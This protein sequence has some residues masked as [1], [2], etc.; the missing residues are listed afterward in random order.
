MLA[1]VKEVLDA[2]RGCLRGGGRNGKRHIPRCCCPI[3]CYRNVT[4][5]W[6]YVCRKGDVLNTELWRIIASVVE[7]TRHFRIRHK[8]QSKK[9]PEPTSVT[10]VWGTFVVQEEHDTWQYVCG[11]CLIFVAYIYRCCWFYSRLRTYSFPIAMI[12]YHLSIYIYK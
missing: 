4:L 2:Y 1:H 5:S 3:E 7:N 6:A 8:H 12:S 11:I 10:V 9:A